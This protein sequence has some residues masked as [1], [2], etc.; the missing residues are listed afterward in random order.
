MRTNPHSFQSIYS[1]LLKQSLLEN[2]IIYAVKLC[3]KSV[4]IRS[5]LVHIFPHPD[6]IRGDT[7]YSPYSVRMREN[8][9]QKNSEYGHFSRSEGCVFACA[10][11]WGESYLGGVLKP[12]K[13]LR[14]S[15]LR[16]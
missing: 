7:S 5:F 11:W 14:Q 12:V 16:K 13:H 3:M 6:W 4:R 2:G 1:Q 15:V 8:T 10:L 9:D